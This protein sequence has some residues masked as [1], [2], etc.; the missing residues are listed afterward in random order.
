MT[1]AV[2]SR[3]HPQDAPLRPLD[4]ARLTFLHRG[5]SAGERVSSPV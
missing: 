1:N 5:S 2:R 4:G 3:R